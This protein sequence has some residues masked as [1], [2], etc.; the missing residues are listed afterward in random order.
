MYIVRTPIPFKEGGV[1]N[2][3]KIDENEGG[4][5]SFC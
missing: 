3:F 4:L 5:E 2:F 1:L